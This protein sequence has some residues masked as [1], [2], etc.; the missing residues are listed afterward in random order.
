MKK[1]VDHYECD[2]FK[3]FINISSLHIWFCVNGEMSAIFASNK[4]TLHYF[5][6]TKC[7]RR[8]NEKNADHAC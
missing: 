2:R 5:F 8:T 1:Y 6:K 7:W 4:T 3:L